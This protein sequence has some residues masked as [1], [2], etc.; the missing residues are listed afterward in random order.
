MP[1]AVWDFVQLCI[2]DGALDRVN[3]V[4]ALVIVQEF[5][6]NGIDWPLAS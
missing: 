3:S 6:D 5:V 4:Q 1:D 2:C